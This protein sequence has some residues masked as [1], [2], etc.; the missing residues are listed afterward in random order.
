M[1]LNTL[2]ACTETFAKWIE[3]L[4]HHSII[5]SRPSY[6]DQYCVC[7]I[8]DLVQRTGNCTAQYPHSLG[9]AERDAFR[10]SPC[11]PPPFFV[12]APA[13]FGASETQAAPGREKRSR[14]HPWILT[15]DPPMHNDGAASQLVSLLWAVLCL[16]CAS[17]VRIRSHG[18]CVPLR[19]EGTGT[20]SRMRYRPLLSLSRS[21]YGRNEN[22]LASG[23][24]G[25][26][27]CPAALRSFHAHVV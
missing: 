13:T 3:P 16:P 26:K 7:R 4:Q 19:G 12:P 5:P 15:I 23:P 8:S 6:R 27:L 25:S 14:R 17:M 18:H 1:S 9:T 21:R 22:T 11:H 24:A 2:H 20:D 10:F